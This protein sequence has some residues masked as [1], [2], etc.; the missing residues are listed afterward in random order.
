MSDQAISPTGNNGLRPA[1]QF[2][3]YL[4][5]KAREDENKAPDRNRDIVYNSL[6]AIL[7]AASVDEMWSADELQSN[8]GKDLEDVEM[9]IQWFSVHE[10]TGE[11]ES[12][13]GYYVWVHATRLD[14]QGELIFNTGSSLIMGKL[15][16][17]EAA[18]LLGTPEARCVIKGTKT[19]KGRV[20][21][22]RPIA[23][24]AVQGT[25]VE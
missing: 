5:N 3:D 22:L 20:L 17:L 8:A 4:A 16:Y 6:D 11:F 24:R 23:Q 9:E 2:M 12:V 18:E 1:E 13:L 14:G 21:K 10:G 15:R 19:S 25:V 7:T